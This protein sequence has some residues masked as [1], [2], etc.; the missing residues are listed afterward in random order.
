MDPVLEHALCPQ[1][2]ALDLDVHG[3]TELLAA[4][5]NVLTGSGR[6]A[7]EPIRRALLRR[8]QAAS[9]AV[10][11]GLAIPHARVPGIAAPV[12][13]F[14]RTRSPIPFGAPDG[15]PVA[16]FFVILVPAEGATE[17][18]LQLLRAVAELFSDRAFRAMLGAARSAAAVATVFA[19]RIGATDDEEPEALQGI[20]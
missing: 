14:A 1:E 4:V 15:K 9:T 2:I 16:E 3:R 11:S 20:S 12:T 7:A 5:A 10:G 6:I 18:H 13:L 8:E 19:S 17:T